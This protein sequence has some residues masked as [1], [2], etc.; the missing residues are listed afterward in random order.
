M[1]HHPHVHMIKCSCRAAALASRSLDHGDCQAAGLLPARA[2][3]VEAVPQADDRE[4][5]RGARRRPLTF[6][7]AH[8]AL[9]DATA[10]AAYLAPLKGTRWFV[11][12]K[13]PFAGPKAV[14]AYLSRCTIVSRS[15]T[16]AWSRPM[17]RR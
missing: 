14:L 1:I 10:F 13:R 9:V 15:R 7:G 11:Y 12:A 5:N 3:A 6:C 16:G 8:A 2:R 4:A 17:P